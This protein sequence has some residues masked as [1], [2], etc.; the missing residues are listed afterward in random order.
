MFGTL[1][2]IC[3]GWNFQCIFIEQNQKI[4]IGKRQHVVA[5]RA[6]DNKKKWNMQFVL[7]TIKR[8]NKRKKVYQSIGGNMLGCWL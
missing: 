8:M 4:K 7:I 5:D 6:R 3:F 2:K 1:H